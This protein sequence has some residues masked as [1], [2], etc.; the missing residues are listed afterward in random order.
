MKIVGIGD[1]FI[2]HRHIRD[3]LAPLAAWVANASVLNF[4]LW[5]LN[6]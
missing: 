4:A 1:L 6:G 2:P 3:G 5:W